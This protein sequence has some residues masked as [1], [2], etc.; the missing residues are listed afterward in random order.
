MNDPQFFR[1]RLFNNNNP[2]E[3]YTQAEVDQAHEEI[4]QEAEFDAWAENET[5]E[6]W[7]ECPWEE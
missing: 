7:D 6:M 3:N 5:N 2:E 1:R 4:R